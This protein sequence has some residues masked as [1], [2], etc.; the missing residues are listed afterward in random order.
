MVLDPGESRNPGAWYAVDGN[1]VPTITI[2][3]LL[4]DDVDLIYLDIEGYETKALLGG[5]NTIERCRPVIGIEDKKNNLWA[6]YGHKRS[7]VDMLI[8]DFGYREV[9]RVH[10]D[11]ILAP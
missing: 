5:A 2:D 4:R 9:A 11:V 3:A 10:L 1:D 7:P 8:S 6:K